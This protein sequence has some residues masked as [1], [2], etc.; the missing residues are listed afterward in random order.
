METQFGGR[1]RNFTKGNHEYSRRTVETSRDISGKIQPNAILKHY[2][3]PKFDGESSCDLYRRQF[4]VVA[5]ANGWTEHQKAT[6]LVLA[7]QGKALKILQNI[8]GSNYYSLTN[9][10]ELR[11]GTKH[12]TP[13]YQSQLKSR[14]QGP[15]ETLQEYGTEVGRL[16]R[17]AYPQAPKE[18]LNQIAVQTFIDG[19]RSTTGASPWPF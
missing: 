11:Y 15:S 5:M 6:E 1:D 17:L 14:L 12:L 16:T 10:L 4:E 2:K 3:M 9:A 19:F 18:C 8:P 13:V 7:L